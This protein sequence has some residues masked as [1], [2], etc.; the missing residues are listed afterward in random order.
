MDSTAKWNLRGLLIGN[1]WISP[2]DQYPAY[3]P[4]AYEEGIVKEGSSLSKN[5]EVL[6]S[7]CL[8]R[9][10]AG[11]NKVDIP[12]C[13]DVLQEMLKRTTD[14]NKECYNMYDIRLRDS[15]PSCGNELAPRFGKHEAIPPPA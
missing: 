14:G 10:E 13:E 6:Q 2:A 8:S 5:L 3:L 15:F 12:E 11:K 4:F 9:L 1:G 7:V